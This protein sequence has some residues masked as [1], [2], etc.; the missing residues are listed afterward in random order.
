MGACAAGA[1]AAKC[2]ALSNSATAPTTS[3]DL[4]HLYC[5]DNGAGH[6]TLAIYQEEVVAAVG[7]KLV[8][9]VLPVLINGVLKYIALA[10]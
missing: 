8:T 9:E 7:I 4:C 10:A 1:T 6:A 5:A 3:V 2:L